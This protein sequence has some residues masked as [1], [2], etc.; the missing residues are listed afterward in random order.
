M[1]LAIK[2]PFVFRVKGD[3]Q[4]KIFKGKPRR[5]DSLFKHLNPTEQCAY[6]NEVEIFGEILRVSAAR[7]EQGELLIVATN[8]EPKNAVS[9]YLRRWEIENLF[10]C[11]KGRGFRFEDTHITKM[12]RIKKLTALLAIAF[13]WA[14][15][16]GEWKAL[17]K[18][19]RFKQHK[20]GLRPQNS[21][22]R[23]GLDCIRDIVTNTTNRW[24]LFRR[25]LAEIIPK[26]PPDRIKGEVGVC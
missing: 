16:V 17:K 20:N 4:C 24:R 9:M 7:S 26:N 3:S 6:E 12:D 22:F 18:P 21:Y 10:Q 5:V 23:Y 2:I 13:C 14:H 15:K 1:A 11:L 8:K 25:I 19:I